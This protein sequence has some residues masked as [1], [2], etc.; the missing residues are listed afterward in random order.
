MG[1]Y[2]VIREKPS[3]IE[4]GIKK[5]YEKPGHKYIKRYIGKTG[6]Y[7][8]EYEKDNLKKIEKKGKY[9]YEH[10][11]DNLKKIGKKMQKHFI[12]DIKD[13]TKLSNK[14]FHGTP[15]T[16]SKMNNKDLRKAYLMVNTARRTYADGK[17]KSSKDN[18]TK[19]RKQLNAIEKEMDSRG[20]KYDEKKHEGWDKIMQ[21]PYTVNDA[22]GETT[23]DLGNGRYVILG[24]PIIGTPRGVSYF[25][26]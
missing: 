20:I 26:E 3:D 15:K 14:A 12:P 19:T 13:T 11:E 2:A 8:Y 18:Y 22:T 1:Y 10:E 24:E 25:S 4:H 16:F 21:V 7:I 6:K 9:I 23:Y 5:G 17:S